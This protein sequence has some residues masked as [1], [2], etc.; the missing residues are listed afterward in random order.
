MKSDVELQRDVLDELK[1]EPAVDAAEIGVT[2]KDGVVTLS[3][4]VPSYS[5]KLAAEHAAKRVFGVKGVA[6]EIEVNLPAFYKRTDADIVRAAVNALEWNTLVPDDKIKV[7]VTDGWLTLEGEVD[8]QYQKVAALDA[9][10]ALAGVKWVSNLMTVKPK[11]SATSVKSDIVGAFKRS[12]ELDAQNILVE[13]KGDEVTLS[14]K[15]RSLAE[16]GEAERTAWAAQGVSRVFNK[17]NIN[18]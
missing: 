11:V 8:W 14:G 17:I 10:Q 1:F 16:W 3:G 7:T 13:V 15:V 12:A 4:N 5:E 2:V 6:E 18:S 9:V